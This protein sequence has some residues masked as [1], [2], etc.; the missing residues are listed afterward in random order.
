MKTDK[1]GPLP[2]TQLYEIH[3]AAL[4]QA[5]L[6]A[7]G[8]AYYGSNWREVRK[9]YTAEQMRAYALRERAAEREKC[10]ADAQLA[11]FV[12]ER[13]Q[14]T[15]DGL[16]IDVWISGAPSLETIDDALTP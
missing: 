11:Q 4:N 3:N 6:S 8:V 16:R 13:A 1:L 14:T 15:P 7:T 9:L 5:R 12:R 10:A 2:D